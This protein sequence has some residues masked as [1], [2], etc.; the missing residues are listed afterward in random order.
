MVLDS[1]SFDGVS[2]ISASEAGLSTIDNSFWFCKQPAK[3]SAAESVKIDYLI[4]LRI[5]Q[6]CDELKQIF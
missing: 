5:L 1:S 4:V 6:Y 3:R 2:A